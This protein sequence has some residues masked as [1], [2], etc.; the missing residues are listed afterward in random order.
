MGKRE[1]DTVKIP[2]YKSGKC[3]IIDKNNRKGVLPI[4]SIPYAYRHL[5][6]GG[7]G[8]VTGFIFHPTDPKVMYCRTDIGG[9][10]A[11]DEPKVYTGADM[12]KPLSQR[13]STWTKASCM[14]VGHARPCSPVMRPR[15]SACRASFSAMRII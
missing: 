10:F 4:H 1:S 8:Y 13:T 9:V 14:T 7:G 5:P 2:L 12:A 15:H 11:G 3:G 6:I